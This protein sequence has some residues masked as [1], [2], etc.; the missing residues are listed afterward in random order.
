MANI[1]TLIDAW[2]STNM[3]GRNPDAQATTNIVI[4]RIQNHFSN[5]IIT[6]LNV[7]VENNINWRVSFTI[8][9]QDFEFQSPNYEFE[10]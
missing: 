7:R 10:I 6:N 4:T 3:H 9:D 1:E 2:V 8:V 5:Y